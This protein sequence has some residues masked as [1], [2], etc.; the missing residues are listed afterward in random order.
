MHR[1]LYEKV[2][3]K[4]MNQ[5]RKTQMNTSRVLYNKLICIFICVKSTVGC[6]NVHLH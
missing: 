5:Q 6:F 3:K 2:S 1:S 4:D